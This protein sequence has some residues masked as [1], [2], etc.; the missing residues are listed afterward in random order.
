[1]KKKPIYWSLLLWAFLC[2]CSA[3]IH[4]ASMGK[5]TSNLKF[6]PISSSILPT[7]EVRILYQDSDGYIWLPTYNGLVR[8][9]GYSVVNYGLN[10]GTNLPFNCYLNVV[11]EDQNRDLW[12][13]AEKGVFKLHKF[14]G[15]IERIGSDRL[16]PLNAADIFCARNGDIWVG[17]DCGLFRKRKEEEVFERIDLPSQRLRAVSSIIEDSEGCIWVAAC[18]NGLFRYDVEQQVFY[19]YIDENLR[20]SNVV[21]QDDK[22]QIWVGTW[23]K[24]LVKLKTPYTTGRMQY[25]R[26]HRIE[27]QENSLFDN[28][29]YTIEQDEMHRIWVGTRSGLSIMHDENDFYSFENYLPG[30]EIGELPYNEVSSIQRTHDNQMWISMFGG[31]VCQ[32]QTENK[33]YGTDRMEAVRERYNT[34]SIRSIFYAGDD[35]YWM[36]IIGFGMILYNDRTHTCIN[37]REHPDFKELPYTSTVDAI[38]RRKK[39]GEICFGTYSRGVWLYDEK[40]HK[41]RTLNRWTQKKFD[42]DCVHM[43]MDDSEG[44]L[45]IGTRQGVYILDADDELHTLSEWMPNVELEFLNSRIFDI[46]E[47]AERNIWI[48][49]NYEGVVRINLKDKTCRRYAVGQQRDVQ[50]VFC[51]LVDSHQQ[52]WAGSMWNGLSYYDRQLDAFVTINSFSTIENKGI[53][54]IVEDSRG[55]IWTTTN[56]TVLSF[57]MNEAHVLENISYYAVAND[58]ETF[59]FNRASCCLL[60]DGRLIFGS[61]HG[62]RSFMTD[63]T[64]YI[65]SS[66]SLVFTDFKVHNRSLRDMTPG[67]RQRFSKKDVN[68]TDEIVLKHQ[69][70]NFTIEFSLLN[71]VNPQENMYTYRLEGYDDKEIVVDAQRHFATYNNLPAGTYLFRLKGTNE[72]GV[73][74][75]TER[76]LRIRI[77]PAPWLTWWAYCIYAVLLAVILYFV[78]RFLRYKMRMQHEI[79]ISKIEKQK[80]QEINHLKLQFFT[81]ITHELMTPLSIIL[82][83]LENLKSGGD[84]RTLHT[85]MTANATRLMRLIQQVLEFRKVESGN[86][87]ICVSYGDISSFLRSCAEAFIPLLGKRRQLLSFEST[88]DAIFGFFDADKLDKIVYNL[89]SNAAKYTP[90]DGRICVRTLLTDEHTLQIDVVNTGELMTQK[91]IDGLFKRFY[92]GDYRRHNTIGTG[93]GLALVKDLVGLH[94]GTIE[95]FSNEQMGNCFRITLPIGKET[96]RQG[97]IDETVTAQRQTAF[98]V[99]IYINE[100]EAD[101]GPDEKPDLLP[102]SDYTLLIVD[103]NE[104]LCMLFSNLL[105]NYFRVKTAINGRQALDVLQEGGIDLVVSDIMMPEM[106]G[107]ELCRYIKNKFE[108]CHIPVI[109]LTAKR[110]EES[111][112]E[113]YNSGADGYISKPCNFSLLYAQ[114]VNCLKRQER[115]GADFRKQVVFE[116]DKLEYTSLDETFLQR[117]I[118]CV[119]AHLNDVEF[120]QAEF[121]NEMG[122]S[123]TVLTEKLKSL[124]GLTPSAFL[125]NVRLTAACKLMDRQNKVRI[126]E[127]AVAVGFNDPK[128]FS[129]CFKKKYGMTPKE[130]MEQD[131]S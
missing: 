36:G 89:L 32:I 41:V 110:A 25:D 38:V 67:E 102:S 122:T 64:D 19:T 18:E 5:Y 95:V 70:N 127:L 30:S 48:A 15:E 14:T 131:R 97:E 80:I 79:Q 76:V 1:M 10:D 107:I 62:T 29:V 115:K 35:E 99:P 24:G 26:F 63:R 16:E 60:P 100:A 11:V 106:D 13:A 61:S 69:D 39:T 68:Y 96:Y 52:V 3:G 20:F 12:I 83:S 54:N 6:I 130:Y 75:K 117:A 88:P 71:Y 74:G 118:D 94:H 129:T 85:V 101:N 103:D 42:S 57:T 50:N 125:L 46:K 34:S 59:S 28:I 120:G 113:G 124:T 109:L 90:E 53:T 116:V 7:N 78:F 55:K 86:L 105:S 114:I 91:T 98:P 73:W 45:W 126:A 81:N 33:K 17:G 22:H 47:D 27:G 112:I 23:D 87:K 40:T 37:Y 93:I 82:A 66:F 123:R 84:Q 56:N 43:L 58:M 119:N 65:P 44:N 8:Y 92:E 72:D 104:E 31:G 9:D 128:Y 4:A 51:L 49:T 108:Y 111:Q 77:L 121:V 2:L 21:Y